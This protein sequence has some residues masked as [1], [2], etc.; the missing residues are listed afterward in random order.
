MQEGLF[1]PNLKIPTGCIGC[2][3]RDAE[4]DGG[5]RL[6]PCAKF[7]DCEGQ[8]ICCP[9]IDLARRHK[10]F[11]ITIHRGKVCLESNQSG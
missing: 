5:C 2:G 11:H 10:A 8:F 3:E 1:F 7:E 6:M 9:I 4:Y